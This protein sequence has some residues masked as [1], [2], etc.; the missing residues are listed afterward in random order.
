M[1][2][3]ATTLGAGNVKEQKWS[4]KAWELAGSVSTEQMLRPPRCHYSADLR[5][6]THDSD[7]SSGRSSNRKYGT[8]KGGTIELMLEMLRLGGGWNLL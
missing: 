1:G 2:S 3:S 6:T 8:T 5:K 7:L 4:T